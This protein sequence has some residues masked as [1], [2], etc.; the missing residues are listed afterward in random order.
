MTARSILKKLVGDYQL[1][2]IYSIATSNCLPRPALLKAEPILDL[3]I[4][5][6]PGL[7]EDLQKSDWSGPG[8]HGFAVW[9][10]NELVGVCWYWTGKSLAQRNVGQLRS[11]EAELIQITV[12]RAFR[13]RGIGVNLIA[14]TTIQMRAIGFRR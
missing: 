6:R 9:A 5:R 2:H 1:W 8:A 10:A 4:F 12:A 14:E 11:D 3:S 7:D 13:G